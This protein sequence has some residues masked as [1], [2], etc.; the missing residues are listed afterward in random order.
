MTYLLSLTL[1]LLWLFVPINSYAS[2]YPNDP[3]GVNKDAYCFPDVLKNIEENRID[4]GSGIMAHH[5]LPTDPLRPEV[6]TIIIDKTNPLPM[7]EFFTSVTAGDNV[8]GIIIKTNHGNTYAISS[9]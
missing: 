9:D 7:G 8:G 4:Y 5:G 3:L 2:C 1:N 6:G